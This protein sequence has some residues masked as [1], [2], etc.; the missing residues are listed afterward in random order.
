MAQALSRTGD[1]RT[2][3]HYDYRL[4]KSI[5]SVTISPISL[6]SGIHRAM[7]LPKCMVDVAAQIE[8]AEKW[9]P[10]SRRQ[11]RLA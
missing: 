2:G 6:E 10:K 9:Y 5:G 1:A 11:Y 8:L 7:S 4:G 3:F